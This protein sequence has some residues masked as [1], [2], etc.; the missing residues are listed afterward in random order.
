MAATI[1]DY[2]DILKNLV[3]ER[4]KERKK[5]TKHMNSIDY[6]RRIQQSIL[7]DFNKDLGVPR[8]D[9]FVIWMPRDAVGGDAYWSRRAGPNYFLAL[10]DCTGHGVP[11]ALMTMTVKAILDRIIDEV[12]NHNPGRILQELNRLLQD[13]LRQNSRD[14]L[15]NDGVDL[16]LCLVKPE[17]NRLVYAGSKITLYCCLES[18]LTEIK[19]DRQSLGYKKSK[20]DYTYSNNEI[21]LKP[22]QVFFLTTDGMIDQNEEN[23]AAFGQKRFR[24]MI[25]DNCQLSLS[26]QN[27]IYL[28][29]LE[30]FMGGE[31]QRDDITMIG[32]K[33]SAS[34]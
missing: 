14:A 10:F 34:W 5:K 29:H 30:A 1:E 6:A 27:Q 20:T 11:G 15:T 21:E 23:G 18:E 3:A 19:G 13:S 28:L 24:R 33:I 2:H 16:G 22:G 7:P 32:F 26:D 25:L 12:Q 9:Y 31:A 4:T 8:E 17:Q